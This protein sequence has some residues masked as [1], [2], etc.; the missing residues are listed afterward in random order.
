MTRTVRW[1]I[2]PGVLLATACLAY[3]LIGIIC[4]ALSDEVTAVKVRPSPYG[5]GWHFAAMCSASFVALLVVPSRRPAIGLL[6][7]GALL[8][9]SFHKASPGTIYRETGHKAS[10]WPMLSWPA[11]AIV[12]TGLIQLR[13]RKGANIAVHGRLASSPP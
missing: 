8:A 7:A 3:L 10:S 11:G 4:V 13:R 9:Y 2:A 12:A 5:D 6:I 1:I